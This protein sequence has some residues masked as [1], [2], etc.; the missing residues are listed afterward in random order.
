MLESNRLKAVTNMEKYQDKTRAW[1]DSKVKL[2]QFKVKNLVPL[3]SPCTENTGK[4][5]IKW[6]RPYVVS[7]K[8]MSGT[9]QLSDTQGRVLEH[10]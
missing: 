8:M 10:S 4:F 2:K 6:T 1:R 9:Y 7:E 3:R 5:D